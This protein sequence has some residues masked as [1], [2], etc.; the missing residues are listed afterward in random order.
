M[1]GVPLHIYR[2]TEMVLSKN[3]TMNDIFSI[4]HT[5]VMGLTQRGIDKVIPIYLPANFVNKK[6]NYK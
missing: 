3:V 4:K 6:N 2:H 1:I 5:K